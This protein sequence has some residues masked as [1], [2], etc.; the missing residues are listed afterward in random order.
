MIILTPASGVRFVQTGNVCATRFT[1]LAV[2]AMV[3]G[4]HYA[5]A[6]MQHV[7]ECLW[8]DV[9]LVSLCF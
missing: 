1:I 2:I 3:L 8:F 9:T 5:A 6:L 4:A 7:S